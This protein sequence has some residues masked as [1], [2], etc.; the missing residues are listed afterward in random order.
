MLYFRRR[1]HGQLVFITRA[2]AARPAAVP[3]R[4]R[5]RPPR[6]RHL[7]ARARRRADLRG[8]G[9][10]RRLPSAG[11]GARRARR[12]RGHH[13]AAPGLRTQDVPM[14]GVRDAVR[15][16]PRVRRE[17]GSAR[18]QSISS[19]GAAES[20]ARD[21]ARACPRAASGLARP[22]RRR[23]PN[24]DG[25]RWR[26]PR[27]RRRRAPTARSRSRASSRQSSI[28]SS[29]RLNSWNP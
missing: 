9:G 12:G 22:A 14:G 4:G 16:L 25:C 24:W 8:C 18:R 13:G 10:V 29:D 20:S 15:P 27:R 17:P 2:E 28:A 3:P 21:A 23:S 5:S 6:A 1:P 11:R 19:S 26:P 7:H